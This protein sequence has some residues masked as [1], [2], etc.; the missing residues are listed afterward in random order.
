MSAQSDTADRVR[1]MLAHEKAVR[2]V[3]MFGTRSF[4]VREQLLVGALR[5]GGLLV[6][7]DPDR[8]GEL[9]TRPGA[10]Q[11]TMGTGRD[12]GAGW[13]EVEPEALSGEGLAFWVDVALARRG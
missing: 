5:T 13:I 11:A 6:R 1:A 2:E 8:H 12:M 4:M 3:S 9:I 10:R 7:V